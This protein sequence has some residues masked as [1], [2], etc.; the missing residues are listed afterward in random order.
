MIHS[1]HT[2]TG[3]IQYFGAEA[4]LGSCSVTVIYHLQ[5]Y[6]HLP[7]SNSEALVRNAL[8]CIHLR[9]IF[10]DKISN[11]ICINFEH[12]YEMPE[13]V[14]KNGANMDVCAPCVQLDSNEYMEDVRALRAALSDIE[15][16]CRP[17]FKCIY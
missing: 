12:T 8:L 9:Y 5:H 14:T 11:K 7:S 13:F 16:A 6:D 2:C 4:D 3:P 15:A 1:V 10:T 17:V